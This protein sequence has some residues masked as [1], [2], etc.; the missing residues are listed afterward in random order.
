M[1]AHLVLLMLLVLLRFYVLALLLRVVALHLR[2][3]LLLQLT[4]VLFL[5]LLPPL[6]LLL[7]QCSFQASAGCRVPLLLVRLP[8]SSRLLA[9]RLLRLQRLKLH[10]LCLRRTQHMVST[11]AAANQLL[12]RLS[13]WEDGLLHRN[14][15]RA[16]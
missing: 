14:H 5:L 4:L 1:R 9:E 15:R 16:L 11:G 8:P 7:L 2:Q 3:L 12:T 10:P 6:L 13:I